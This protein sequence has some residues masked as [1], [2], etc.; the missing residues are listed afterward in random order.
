MVEE[1]IGTVITVPYTV[2]TPAYIFDCPAIL[3][4]LFSSTNLY[5][6]NVDQIAGTI[7][8]AQVSISCVRIY[9]L[10]LAT[11]R[12]RH[13]IWRE[14]SGN[15]RGEKGPNEERT[16]ERWREKR[17]RIK[18]RLRDDD[19]SLELKC[20]N[21]SQPHSTDSKLC[22]KWETEKVIQAIKTNKNIYLEARKLIAP[23]PSQT[24]AQAAKSITVNNSSQTEENISKIKYPP[25]KLLQPLSSLPTPNL[26]TSTPAVSTSSS[27]TTQA[28]LLPHFQ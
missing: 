10:H 15:E 17:G 23:Q 11:G 24:Y 19:C 3:A 28:Q 13:T 25:L 26:S 22:P 8:W 6:D 27:S 4:A 2:K 18:E 5:E 21:C 14:G 20:V 16:G 7:I 1:L 9:C 12:T